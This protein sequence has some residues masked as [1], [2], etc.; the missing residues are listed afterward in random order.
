MT[1]NWM[2]MN[3]GKWI[4]FMNDSKN[5]TVAGLVTMDNMNDLIYTIT[6]A[7]ISNVV[8]NNTTMTDVTAANFMNAENTLIKSKLLPIVKTV[9]LPISNYVDLANSTVRYFS[10]FIE[11]VADANFVT[12]TC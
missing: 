11:I 9:K 1:C 6:T 5:W 10:G 2:V 4:Q 8:I 3:N 12:M 7:S